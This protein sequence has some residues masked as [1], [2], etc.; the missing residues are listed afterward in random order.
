MKNKG[1]TISG[2]LK[3]FKDNYFFLHNT[4]DVFVA[5]KIMS[6]GFIFESQLPHSSDRINPNEPIEITYF[7]FQRKDYGIYTMVLAIPRSVYEFYAEISDQ[8]VIS[9][10]EVITISDPWVGE[11]DEPVFTLP[12]EHVLGYFNINSMEFF[13]NPKWDPGYI[14]NRFLSSLKDHDKSGGKL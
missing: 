3:E 4:K 11:N 6:E 5:E 9:I 7:L 14:N 12:P 8:N 13:K 1:E 2:I 10:E